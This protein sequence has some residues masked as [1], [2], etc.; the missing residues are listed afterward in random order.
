MGILE[1]IA[2]LILI[3]E[4]I[5]TIQIFCNL[6]YAGKEADNKHCVF[7]PRCVLIVPCKGLDE[8]FDENIE[9]FY[10]QEYRSYHLWFVVQEEKDPAYEQLLK[11]KTRYLRRTAAESVKILISGPAATASQKLHNLLYAY[12]QIPE[13]TEM[14]AFADSDA[15]VGN[16]WLEDLIYPLHREKNGATSGYRC[17]IPKADN[18]ATIALSALNA[19]VCQFLGNSRFNLAWGGS[20]GIS[21]KYFREFGVDKIWAQ[22]LSDDLSLS[23]AVRKNQ[24]KMVF[25]P[26]CM[27]ASFAT[28]SW[29]QLWEFAR[30]QFIITRVYTPVMWWFSFISSAISGFG[31]MIAVALAFMMQSRQYS[32]THIYWILAAGLFIMQ[33]SRMVI[34][35]KLIA[36]LLPQ[37][38]DAFRP[39]RNMDRYFFWFW[40]MLLFC[41]VLSSAFGRTITWRNIRYRL[42]S[43][44]DVRIIKNS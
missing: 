38:K 18:V 4:M 24:C 7:H 30:R 16:K 33:F 17:F 40:S 15:C 22:S 43:P 39:V 8:T 5:V 32:Y 20:M 21:V 25:V 35:Q 10:L 3:A 13:D 37:Y 44:G 1:Y 42:Q 36:Q 34:R 26:N 29:G 23:T 27:T 14:L 12:Q 9:S 11:L 41:I 28:S 19:K 6:H 31:V 2:I